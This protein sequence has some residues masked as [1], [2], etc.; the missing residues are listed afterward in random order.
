VIDT[1]QD[2]EDGKKRGVDEGVFISSHLPEYF[3]P[4]VLDIMVLLLTAG[5]NIRSRPL[6]NTSELGNFIVS[7]LNVDQR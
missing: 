4:N 1:A 7:S 6:V 5:V 3:V 2:N